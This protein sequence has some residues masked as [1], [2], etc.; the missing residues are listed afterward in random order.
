MTRFLPVIEH[1]MWSDKSNPAYT[2]VRLIIDSA[3]SGT[4]FNHSGGH[5]T[6]FENHNLTHVTK[7]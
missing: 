2:I 7:Q 4:Q 6:S 1:M 3:F 5:M